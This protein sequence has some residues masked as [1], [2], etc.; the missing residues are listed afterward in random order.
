VFALPKVTH[1]VYCYLKEN[2]LMSKSENEECKI[3]LSGNGISLKRTVPLAIARH[4]MDLVLSGKVTPAA[5]PGAPGLP[6]IA[7][8]IPPAA[9]SMDARQFIKSKQPGTDS[10]R[11]ACVAYF[12]TNSEKKRHFKTGDVKRVAIDA[13]RPFAKPGVAVNDAATKYGYL[14]SAGGG[15]KQLS[16]RGETVV[17]LL[18]NKDRLK[19]FIKSNPLKKRRARKKPKAK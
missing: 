14:A 17:E 5:T 11:V 15:A 18:P 2:I 19:E 16:P 9:Q 12:L 4:V 6:P 13:G 7:P 3:E 1:Y 10:E 8:V